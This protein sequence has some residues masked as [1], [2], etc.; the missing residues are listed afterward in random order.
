MDVHN[1]FAATVSYLAGVVLVHNPATARID[2]LMALA[3]SAHTQ[4]SVHVHVVAGHVQADETL[5]ED[6]P[7]GPGGA[8]KD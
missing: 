3:G 1:Q 7:S 6:G 8:Q 5:E 2:L 4:G